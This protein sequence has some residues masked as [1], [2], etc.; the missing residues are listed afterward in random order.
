MPTRKAAMNIR[1]SSMFVLEL[2][3]A[4]SAGNYQL[5]YCYIPLG[6]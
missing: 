3:G 2:A 4:C 1:T 5:Y 6:F